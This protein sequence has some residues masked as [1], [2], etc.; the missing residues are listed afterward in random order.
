VE[1]GGHGMGKWQAPAMQHWK[2]DMI[3]W[4]NK[5]LGK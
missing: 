2:S 5:T 4:L 1:G 3:D